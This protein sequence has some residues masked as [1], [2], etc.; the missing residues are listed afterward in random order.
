MIEV[1]PKSASEARASELLALL[2]LRQVEKNLFLGE[3]EQRSQAR[4]FGGQVLAQA[5]RAA[6]YTLEGE[7][8]DKQ[9]HSLHGYF[10]RP[11][12]PERRVLYEVERIRDGRS[13]A[14]RR[15][16]A[17][18]AGEAIFNLDVSFHIDESG[19]EHAD[20]I[21]NVPRPEMLDDDLDTLREL[22]ANGGGGA[23]QS[24][25]G[26]RPGP[27]E[28]RSVFAPG[29]EAAAAGRY[30]HPVWMRFLVPVD[31]ANQALAR[32]LLAYAS[33]MGLVGTAFL[34]HQ[35]D[36]D[37][38]TLQTASLDHAVWIHR[39]VDVNEWLLFHRTTT[40]ADAARGLSHASF[41][42]RAGELVASISQEGL[43]RT[44]R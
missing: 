16:V 8:L 43:M 36:T 3:N 6:C 29:S 20:A 18:Q 34:P 14:T 26:T 22:V 7:K 28:L 42:D 40:W 10:M 24:F 11:G 1:E 5:L 31:S 44:R 30:W 23:D 17:V 2:E 25:R 27:F 32:S 13:F 4:L 33:D 38:Q 37:P 39:P 19:M 12:D 35:P 21:P 41:F 9:A 15:V